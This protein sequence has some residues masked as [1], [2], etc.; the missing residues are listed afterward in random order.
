ML[1]T[2]EAVGKVPTDETYAFVK[3]YATAI[4]DTKKEQGLVNLIRDWDDFTGMLAIN[5][6]RDLIVELYRNVKENLATSLSNFEE[7]I[8]KSDEDV[9]LTAL[10]QEYERRVAQKRKTRAGKD[11]ESSIE[12]IFNYFGIQTGGKPK[13][14]TAG[15][16]IDN[17]VE[18]KNGWYIGVTLKR[19]LRERWKQTYTTDDKIY[20][21]H[22]IS[23][24]LWVIS[25]DSDLSEQK[26]SELV[27]YR[28]IFFIP[29]NSR[30]L[31]NL[32]SH[33]N[34]GKYL[35]PITELVTQVQQLIETC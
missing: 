34:I 30:V 17:W 21:Q 28:H 26:I 7:N 6:E 32:C 2:N 31:R 29:D 25:D 14:F 23:K 20:V 9:V 12:F 11:L 35:F 1:P 15:L 10:C 18:T 19:T 22:K 4:L 33:P 13:H 27:S 8:S 24:I 3:R 5:K 16:E